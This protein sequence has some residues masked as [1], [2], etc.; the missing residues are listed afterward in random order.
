MRWGRLKMTV[1]EYLRE[2][3]RCACCW[4]Q[5]GVFADLATPIEGG[6]VVP[7]RLFSGQ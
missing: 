3:Q 2:Y 1:V 5:Y 7:A 6:S 4:H